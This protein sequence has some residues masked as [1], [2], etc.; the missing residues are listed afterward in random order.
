[1]ICF[2]LVTLTTPDHKPHA[3]RELLYGSFHF[4][5]WSLTKSQSSFSP[6]LRGPAFCL[7]WL[8]SQTILKLPFPPPVARDLHDPGSTCLVSI[9]RP[10][11]WL[12]YSMC[13]VYTQKQFLNPSWNWLSKEINIY[14][15]QSSAVDSERAAYNPAEDKTRQSW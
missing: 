15:M 3:T 14:Y 5:S 8:Q 13:Q 12:F 2:S 7:G 1:M 6:L 9:N 4:C 11:S 10:E